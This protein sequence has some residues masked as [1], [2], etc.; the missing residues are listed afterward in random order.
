M[1]IVHV[2]NDAT[3]GGAQ[4]FVEGL[5]G[6]WDITGDELHLVVLRGADSLSARYSQAFVSVTYLDVAGNPLRAALTYRRVLRTLRPDVVHSHLLQSDL[7]S[8]LLTP[9]RARRISTVHTTGLSK[10]DPVLSRAVARVVG[11]LSGGFVAAVACNETCLRYTGSMGYRATMH[12]IENGLPVPATTSYDPDSTMFLSLA[13]LH[14]MKGHAILVRAFAEIADELPGWNLTC[15]G[16]GVTPDAGD[17]ADVLEMPRVRQLMSEGRLRLEG[18]TLEP[19][20]YL[21]G[22]AALVISSTYGEASP[23]VAIE[24]VSMAVPVLTTAVGGGP[25]LMAGSLPVAA[26]GSTESLARML[27]AFAALSVGERVELSKWSRA[28]AID[29]FDVRGRVLSY[30]SVYQGGAS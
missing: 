28:Q 5:A 19:E 12:V 6:N 21:E 25:A 14:P 1:R 7:V 2:I 16:S 24:A 8:L 4:T 29:K 9:R 20:R 11:R 15:V 13:R 26:P 23:M 27:R 18:P 3:I 22:A 30:R 10:A 17:L